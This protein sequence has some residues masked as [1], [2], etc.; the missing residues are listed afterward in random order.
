MTSSDGDKA[1]QQN[2]PQMPRLTAE[3]QAKSEEVC[4]LMGAGRWDD[5]YQAILSVEK[6]LASPY[7]AQ[8]WVYKGIILRQQGEED[9]ARNAFRTAQSVVAYSPPEDAELQLILARACEELQLADKSREAYN[10]VLAQDPNHEA[11]Q[12]GLQRLSK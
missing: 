5:A 8:F 1:V 4:T 11:A 12:A 10:A 9:R 3:Q 7:G 6:Q 2:M